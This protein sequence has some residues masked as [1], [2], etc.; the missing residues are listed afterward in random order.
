MS[1][2]HNKKHARI[3]TRSGRLTVLL[4]GA[5]ELEL[6]A[7]VRFG[8]GSLSLADQGRCQQKKPEEEH[9]AGWG[10]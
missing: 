6:A 5:G 2:R 7:Q 3:C 10:G 1:S 9:L 4:L 8:L